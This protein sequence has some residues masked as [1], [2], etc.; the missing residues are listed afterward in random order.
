MKALSTVALA[1]A[2]FILPIAA[3]ADTFNFTYTGTSLNASG[4]LQTDPL[5]GGTYVIT[6]ITG[7]SNGVS[8]TAL[9]PPNTFGGN[10]N[11]LQDPSLTLDFNGLAYLMANGELVNLFGT[12]DAQ[13]EP[14]GQ[15]ITLDIGTLVISRPTAAT[16]EPSSLLLLSTGL[17]GLFSAAKLSPRRASTRP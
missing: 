10:D 2:F 11:L 17:L 7:T 6:G 12:T 14:V 16:P 3:L 8:I 9:E 1:F 15:P 4:Q 13:I 5:L